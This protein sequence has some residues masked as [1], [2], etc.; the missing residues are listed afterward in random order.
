MIDFQNAKSIIIPEGEVAII[1]RGAEILWKKMELPL[2]YQKVEYIEST[3]TQYI[4]TGVK[5]SGNH[6]VEIDYQFTSVPKSGDRNGL[7]GGLETSTGRHGALVSPTTM[8]LEYGYGTGNAYYQ[9]SIPDTNRHV[10]KQAKN[11]VYVDGALIYTF[12]VAIF[13]QTIEAPLGT[14]NFTNYKPAKAKYFASRWWNGDTLIRNYIPCYR[15][16]DGKPGMYD[17]VTETFFTNAGTGEFNFVKP[18]Y[19]K[20]VNYL[21][22]TGTQY[23]DSAYA[24]GNNIKY[25][26]VAS[27]LETKVSSEYKGFFGTSIAPGARCGSGFYNGKIRVQFGSGGAVYDSNYHDCN[28]TGYAN[29]TTY[30]LSKDGFYINGTL[31]W[32]PK[33]TLNNSTNVSI[34]LFN[35][36]AESDYNGTL[37]KIYSFKLWDGDVLVRDFIPVLDWNDRPCMYDKVMDKLFYNQGTGKFLYG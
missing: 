29:T 21:E 3:G 30:E 10:I 14:F 17:T 11:E 19:K 13:Q 9:T 34:Y 20:E 37:L 1:A 23:I 2:E 31:E 8:K 4:N 33:A 6:S 18:T 15:K 28:Y 32:K 7:Y 36:H 12:E 5:L 25:Q 24:S 22:S 35:T 26:I 16:S 27:I